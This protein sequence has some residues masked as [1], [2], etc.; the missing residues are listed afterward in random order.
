MPKLY[1]I[2]PLEWA[3][4]GNDDNPHSYHETITSL[5]QYFVTGD[6]TLIQWGYIL[7]NDKYGPSDITRGKSICNSFEE[8]RK[9]VEEHYQARLAE[10]LI[11]IDN[12]EEV[13]DE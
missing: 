12:T 2:K 6:G 4:L 7:P 10:C 13:G 11:E 3:T 8:G 9:L 1:T 5:G